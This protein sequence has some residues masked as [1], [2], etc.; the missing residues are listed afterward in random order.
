MKNWFIVPLLVLL[1][2]L[3]GCELVGDIFE[4]GVWTGIIIVVIIVALV[5]WLLR[6]LFGRR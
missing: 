5:L 3:S 4:V 2:S 6:K 1:V